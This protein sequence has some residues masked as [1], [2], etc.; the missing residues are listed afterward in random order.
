MALQDISDVILDLHES[1]ESVTRRLLSDNFE[2]SVRSVGPPSKGL[3][4]GVVVEHVSSIEDD[5]LHVYSKLFRG[6]SITILSTT[7]TIRRLSSV[8]YLVQSGPVFY[9]DLLSVLLSS[10]SF[11]PS[12]IISLPSGH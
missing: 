8:V 7:C 6:V 1:D 11:S 2:G 3:S 10:G 5:L 4:S 9:S 12:A